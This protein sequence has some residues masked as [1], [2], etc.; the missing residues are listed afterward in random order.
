M[1]PMLWP[2]IKSRDDHLYGTWLPG[3]LSLNGDNQPA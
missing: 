1:I 2:I 3:Y